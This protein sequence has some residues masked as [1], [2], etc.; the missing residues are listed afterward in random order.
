VLYILQPNENF[1]FDT[2][3]TRAIITLFKKYLNRLELSSINII[4]LII[5]V[6]GIEVPLLARYSYNNIDI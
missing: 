2:N 4:Y 6:A 1:N 5:T 3:K